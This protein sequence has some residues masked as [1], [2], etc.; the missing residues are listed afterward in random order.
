MFLA[1]KPLFLLFFVVVGFWCE[2][3]EV[4]LDVVNSANLVIFASEVG[5]S[6]TKN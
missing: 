3:V 6:K 5:N 4:G 1:E 2:R